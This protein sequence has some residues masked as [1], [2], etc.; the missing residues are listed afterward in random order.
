MEWKEVFGFP[1]Y[2][3]SINGEVRHKKKGKVLKK[4]LNRRGYY[5]VSLYNN[6]SKKCHSKCIHIIVLETFIGLSDRPITDHI[7]RDKTNNK[8]SNLRWV[9]ISENQINKGLQRNN[10][11]G[12]T[13][14]VKKN[15]GWWA[16]IGKG[17][18]RYSCGVWATI[19]EAVK[20]RE[21]AVKKIYPYL[22]VNPLDVATLRSSD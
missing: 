16:Y 5:V 4:V 1:I 7:D 17:K 22:S 14:V 15:N 20:A 18:K 19:E 13:G 3:V 8:L 10:T 12:Y 9:S 11:S 6:N 2:E 21:E